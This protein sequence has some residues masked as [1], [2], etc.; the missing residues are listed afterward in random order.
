VKIERSKSKV[1]T[2][3][4]FKKEKSFK[5][6]SKRVKV[7]RSTTK[8]RT[9]TGTHTNKVHNRSYGKTK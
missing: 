2:A 5:I 3:H 9:E 8:T 4:G 1:P 7:D 6:D